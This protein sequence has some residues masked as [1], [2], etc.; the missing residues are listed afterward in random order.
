MNTSF[1]G[2]VRTYGAGAVM[3]YRTGIRRIGGYSSLKATS[4]TN[5][6]LIAGT[7]KIMKT[8]AGTHP[9]VQLTVVLVATR[10]RN[11]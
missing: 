9:E 3:F 1:K 7:K 5:C 2:V 6:A 11:K 10:N 4:T 8:M